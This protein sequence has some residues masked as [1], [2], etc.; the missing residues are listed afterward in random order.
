MI[1]V[2]T[3]AFLAM[4]SAE[5]KFHSNA[6]ASIDSLLRSGEP[7]LVHNYT[8]VETL[9]LLQRRFGM[10]AVNAFADDLVEYEVEWISRDL[11]DA[12]LRELQSRARKDLSLVDVVS[13]HILRRRG[14]NRVLA[15][16]SQFWEEGFQ[17]A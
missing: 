12:A 6:M 10:E 5:D 8:I 11:H 4:A 15:F 14:L 2:D 7:L 9:A 16:D 3:S 17:Q 13:F 1:L